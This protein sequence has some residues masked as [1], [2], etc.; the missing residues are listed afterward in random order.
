NMVRRAEANVGEG[1]FYAIVGT[2]LA[3]ILLA[4][5]G[6]TAGAIC[7]DKVRGALT[8]LLVTDLSN[9]EIILGKLAAR[10]LPVLGLLLCGAPVLFLALLL[11]GIDPEALVAALLITL[12][13]AVVGCTLALTLSVWGS[14]AHE[15]LLATYMIWTVVLLAS[16]IWWVLERVLAL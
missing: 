13:V 3:L 14:K 11:G 8:H 4:A 6:A 5:P 1:F 12:G 16:P 7:L 15:I 9:A 2:Q 10:L